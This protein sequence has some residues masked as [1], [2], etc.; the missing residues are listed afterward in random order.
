[1]I[2][3]LV[4]TFLDCNFF[5]NFVGLKVHNDEPCNTD[6][7]HEI[8]LLFPFMKDGRAEGMFSHSNIATLVWFNVFG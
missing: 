3:W 1:M 7:E 5:L 2:S 4:I 8:E 6:S